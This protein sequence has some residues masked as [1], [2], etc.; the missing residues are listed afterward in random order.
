MKVYEKMGEFLPGYTFS[1]YI[2]KTDLNRI[3]EAVSSTG[4]HGNSNRRVWHQVQNKCCN[5]GN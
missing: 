1:S 4:F 2:F 3:I 5:Y